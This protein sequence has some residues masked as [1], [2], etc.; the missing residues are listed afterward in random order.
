MNYVMFRPLIQHRAN[1]H[2]LREESMHDVCI[3][4]MQ[5]SRFSK[6][7]AAI[8]AATAAFSVQHAYYA[9][10]F[11][12]SMSVALYSGRAESGALR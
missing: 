10:L 7:H 1:N 5:F 9:F 4:R 11:Q 12:K 2:Q 6:F 8:D 3:W